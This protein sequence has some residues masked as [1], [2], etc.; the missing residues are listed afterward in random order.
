MFAGIECSAHLL[1]LTLVLS[2]LF[3]LD[4]VKF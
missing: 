2:A 1:V 3:I 4:Y